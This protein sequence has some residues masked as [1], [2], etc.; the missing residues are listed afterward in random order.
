MTVRNFGI[1]KVTTGRASG[2]QPLGRSH[3]AH[4]TQRANLILF[5]TCHAFE[6]SDIRE[7]AP[8]ELETGSFRL[9]LAVTL[10]PALCVGA[11]VFGYL[12][13]VA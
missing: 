9:F 4:D 11:A 5:P 3:Y 1:T 10:G 8:E 12:L 13:F 2:A 6:R 7:P